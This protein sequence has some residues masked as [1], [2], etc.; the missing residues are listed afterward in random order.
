MAAESEVSFSELDGSG[1]RIGVLRTRWN[2]EHVSNLVDGIKAG[3]AECKVEPDNIFVKEVPGAYE[4]PYAARLLAMSGT[5]DAIVC[6]GVLIKGET[7]HFEY[8]SDAVSAGIMDVSL[9]TMT[10]VVYGVL[11]CLDEEQVM[12][13]SSNLNGG[14]NHGEDWGK[15]AVEMALMRKEA[16]GKKVDGKPKELAAMG[17]NSVA[18][19]KEGADTKAPG[20]F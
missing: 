7:L 20:F 14:H 12:K 1:V 6:C 3:C 8:I 4:L 18:S 13:R 16:F 2:D 11:N 9:G 5:V 10:P 19:E 15:T 17:F